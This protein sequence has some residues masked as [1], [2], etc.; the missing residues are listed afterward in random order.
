ML[1]NSKRLLNASSGELYK[2]EDKSNGK[3]MCFV[4]K[5][6]QCKDLFNDE[7][8]YIHGRNKFKQLSDKVK[9]NNNETNKSNKSNM[10][11]P[12][13]CDKMVHNN[14]LI[15]YIM[16]NLT[17][18]CNSC[19]V[20]FNIN[21]ENATSKYYRLVTN[22]ILIFIL[23]ILHGGVY[24]IAVLLLTSEISFEV[25]YFFWQIILASGLIVLNTF[26]AYYTVK[27]IVNY[28]KYNQYDLKAYSYSKE[29]GVERLTNH[30]ITN[31][32]RILESKYC[33]NKLELIEKRMVIMHQGAYEKNKIKLSKFIK[34]NNNFYYIIKS[35]ANSKRSYHI[36]DTIKYNLDTTPKIK[37]LLKQKSAKAEDNNIILIKQKSENLGESSLPDSVLK[38]E[39]EGKLLNTIRERDSELGD[40]NNMKL[41]TSKVMPV[42]K[43]IQLQVH[44]KNSRKA[45]SKIDD[46]MK[47]GMNNTYM[48]CDSIIEDMKPE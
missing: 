43:I 36:K 22:I 29:E 48:N 8:Y 42:E 40:T 11:S 7:D 44:K 16:L 20:Y 26:L 33:C 24:T 47:Q 39:E 32:S 13:K 31:F 27:C 3:A 10:I 17:F 12:C 15:R 46:F 35:E 30:D 1:N 18:K 45:S 37:T 5:K 2:E 25:L 34:E 4:C 6:D 38:K 41:S 14:C 9:R 28:L 23:A 19:H 21:Y